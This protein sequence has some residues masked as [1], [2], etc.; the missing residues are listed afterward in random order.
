V[1][2]KADGDLGTDLFPERFITETAEEIADAV[3]DRFRD[4]VAKRTPVARLPQAYT[5]D[6][7]EW[8]KDRGGRTPRTM[9]DSWRRSTVKRNPDGTLTVEIYSD[10]PMDSQGRQKADL[11]EEDT[12]PHLI[13]A[14]RAKALRYP[15][16][17]VFRYNVEVWH[18]GTQGVHMCRD[19]EAEMEVAWETIARPILERKER[20]Y[21]D[22]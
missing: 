9:R 10:E 3:G 20:E 8:I 17:P 13:R 15:F 21:S 6:F 12:R 7:I 18:P 14:K 5:G 1:G 4:G 16:G 19:T 22:V 2:Y 11:V